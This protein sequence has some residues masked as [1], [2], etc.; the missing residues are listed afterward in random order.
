MLFSSYDNLKCTFEEA[1]LPLPNGLTLPSKRVG[2][3][4]WSI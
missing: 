3:G 1:Q 4:L 2:L